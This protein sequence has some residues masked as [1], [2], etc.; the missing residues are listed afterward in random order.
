M[1]LEPM[2]Y[3]HVVAN[4]T[5]DVITVLQD[6][7]IRPLY[8]SINNV[9]DLTTSFL[10]AFTDYIASIDTLD[11]TAQNSNYTYILD[12]LR[13]LVENEGVLELLV[14]RDKYQIYGYILIHKVPKP[15]KLVSKVIDPKIFENAYYLSEFYVHPE[16]RKI[17]IGDAL[18]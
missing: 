9:A 11:E 4:T 3:A 18:I 14:D 13:S 12:D 1:I 7:K 8:L 16:Y 2:K 15:D 5:Q 17:G 10:V 6:D